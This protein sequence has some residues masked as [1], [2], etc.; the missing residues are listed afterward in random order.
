MNRQER[1]A[2]AKRAKARSSD[3]GSERGLPDDLTRGLACHQAGQLVDAEM[4]YRRVL[5]AA[6]HHADALHLLGLVAHQT[7]RQDLAIALIAKAIEQNAAKPVYHVNLGSALNEQNRLE[8]AAAAYREAIRQRPDFAE[9][10]CNLAIVLRSQGKRPLAL[11]AYREA[12]RVRPDLV[13]AHLGLAKVLREAG[14]LENAVAACRAAIGV[15]G[16]SAAAHSAL[17]SALN[18][19]GKH[20]E[21]VAAYREAIRFKP[22]FA[23]AYSNLGFALRRMGRVDEAIAVCREATR[24]NPGLADAHCNLGVA[25]YEVGRLDDAVAA[26]LQALALRPGDV[27]ALVNLVM[28]L[29]DQGRLDDAI[30]FYERALRVQPDLLELDEKLGHSLFEAGR[31]A[32]AL[33]WYRRVLAKRPDSA[34]TLVNYGVAMSSLGQVDEAIA[35]FRRAIAIS[36]NDHTAH[37]GLI[38]VLNFDPAATAREHQA[39]RSRWNERHAH[40]FAPWQAHENERTPERRLRIGYVS[41]YFCRQAATYAFGGII[42]SHDT[43]R[44]EVVCYSD[45]K[46][47]EEDDITRRLAGHADKWHRTSGLSDDALAALIRDD[48]IDIL[49]DLVGHMRGHRLLVFA[50]KPAPIQVTAWGEPTGTGLMAMDYL[51]ADRVLVPTEERPLLAEQVIDLPNFLGY[52]VPDPVARPRALPARTGGHVTF[53]SFSRFEKVNDAVLAA[54]ARI[55]CAVP[56]SRLTL[57]EGRAY[58]D[59]SQRERITSILAGAGIGAER[60]TFL[61]G[62]DRSGHFD[63]YQDIDIALD[64]FPHGGGMTTLDALWMGVPVVTFAGQTIASRLAA[65]SLT[66]LGLTDFVAPDIDGYVNVAIARAADLDTLARLRGTLRERIAASAFGDPT[67][68]ARAVEGAYRAMWRRWCGLEDG[69][70]LTKADS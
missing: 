34:S 12:L 70:V 5:A 61:V 39:E 23:E 20:E 60:I 49:V 56:G 45:L 63:A 52:W 44:F 28:A 69:G 2:A 64:T 50:R 36:P 35:S 48:R 22:D 59:A 19:H 37:S 26:C 54:W 65:A 8:E 40:R 29:T 9:A 3:P 25:L 6:P 24:I 33:T 66:A 10:H 1:R 7:G 16:D 55:L 11:A 32:D 21:A 68:Y 67:Q 41:R 58:V 46:P 42:T 30:R 27:D 43:A 38:F 4:H 17:G 53:G 62:R 51:F 18:E 47:G 13:D 57:K 31:I 14:E 15:R